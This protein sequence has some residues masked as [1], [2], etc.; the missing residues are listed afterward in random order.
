MTAKAKNA[1]LKALEEWLQAESVRLQK[2]ALAGDGG[3]SALY[4]YGM[5]I[6]Y[7]ECGQRIRALE[8]TR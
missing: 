7:L 3:P 4:K 8:E 2:E 1:A 6:A 5:A